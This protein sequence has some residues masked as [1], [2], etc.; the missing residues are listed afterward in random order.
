MIQKWDLTA[1]PFDKDPERHKVR[2]RASKEDIE[3]LLSV[4]PQPYS[5]PFV[6]L[7]KDY[8]W[9]FYLPSLSSDRRGQVEEVI[10]NFCDGRVI[11]GED[12][13]PA[14]S[15]EKAEPPRQAAVE[16]EIKASPEAEHPAQPA[17]TMG[18][19]I[20]SE[21]YED[22]TPP[23]VITEPDLKT[24]SPEASREGLVVPAIAAPVEPE[25]PAPAPVPVA[26]PI[27]ASVSAPVPKEEP[28]SGLA[29]ITLVE[30]VGFYPEP[31]KSSFDALIPLLEEQI[32]RFKLKI[33]LSVAAQIPYEHRSEMS[34]AFLKDACAAK[35]CYRALLLGPSGLDVVSEAKFFKEVQ[36]AAA[37]AHI[38]LHCV[39]GGEFHRESNLMNCVL[40]MSIPTSR[41]S[42]SQAPH[43]RF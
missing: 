4:I 13:S 6:T 38:T 37:E 11:H 26:E 2:L 18:V 15:P 29:E 5:E 22:V 43:K 28:D 41:L 9:F 21:S 24:A 42:A 12:I 33:R 7:A 34:Y 14:R 10:R 39:P 25:M 30:C 40:E 19:G 32:K 35:K 1:A 3:R 17:E 8:N 27:E 23:R 36:S 16:L 20:L 31:Q